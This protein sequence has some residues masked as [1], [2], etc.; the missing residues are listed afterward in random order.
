M[1]AEANRGALV[2]LSTN[3]LPKRERLSFWREV[4]GRQICRVDIEPQSDD[5][6]AAEAALLALPGFRAMWSLNATPARWTR[7]PA[8]L[9]DGDDNFALLMALG[10][11]TGWTQ[12]GRDVEVQ[13]G[14]GVGILHHEPGEMRFRRQRYV[15][16]VVPRTALSER[17]RDLDS[18]AARLIPRGNEALRL[19]RLYLSSLRKTANIADPAL[20]KLVATHVYDLMALAVGATRDGQAAASERGVRAAR[21][22]VIKADF[23]ANPTLSLSAIA[24]RQRITPRYAQMLFKE[25][26]TRFTAY[27]LEQRLV[28]ARRMLTSPSHARWTIGAVAS[29]AGFND[30]A[31]FNR[32]FRRRYGATPSNVRAAALRLGA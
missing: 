27:A 24:A 29:E 32:T 3:D 1:T 8:L 31:Y 18:A 13:P 10:G 11:A 5:P 19:L 28:N 25:E 6:M 12:R 7:T 22:A 23:A 4:F 15:S 14:E 30:L 2:R 17:V 21:L 16:V 9:A 20:G 26:G